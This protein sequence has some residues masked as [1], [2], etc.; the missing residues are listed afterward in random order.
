MR[1]IA[2]IASLGLI[3][4]NA[5]VVSGQHYPNKS[6]RIVTGLPG[7]GSDFT[8]R[9]IAQGISGPLGQP[10][11]IDNR[12]PILVGEIG[13]KAAPDGYTLIAD[14]GSFWVEPLMR[15]TA[16]DPVRDFSPIT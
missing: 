7:A 15:K 5:G 11:I 16:Y 2:A 1:L 9:Q 6:I 10:V 3:V 13:A 4:T 8:T 14:G 12:P